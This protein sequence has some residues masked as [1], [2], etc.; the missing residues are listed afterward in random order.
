MVQ[1]HALEEGAGAVEEEPV[2]APFCGADAKNSV[3]GVCAAIFQADSRTRHVEFRGGRRP[4]VRLSHRELLLQLAA[5]VHLRLSAV[6]G[7]DDTFI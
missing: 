4:A 5:V 2:R 1:A 3:I 6:A 7:N